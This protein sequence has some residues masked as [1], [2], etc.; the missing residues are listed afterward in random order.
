MSSGYAYM[1]ATLP[2]G[3]V[4]GSDTTLVWA[5]RIP[6][7]R[8]GYDGDG[9]AFLFGNTGK[10]TPDNGGIW[11]KAFRQDDAAGA[12]I[13]V[14]ATNGSGT[15]TLT[16][17]LPA[18]HEDVVI[19]IRN[20]SGDI[21]LDVFR[22]GAKLSGAPTPTAFT[23]V[24]LAADGVLLGCTGD[25][26]TLTPET[27]AAGFGG[28]LAFFGLYDG[29][30]SDANLQDISEGSAISGIGTAANW[31][32]A[33]EYD[34]TAEAFGTPSWATGALSNSFT[35]QGGS[36]RPGS[37]VLP[38]EDGSGNWIALDPVQDGQ[39]WGAAPEAST[40]TI[41]L[42]GAASGVTGD[43]EIRTL[44]DDGTEIA[45][46]TDLAGSTISSGTWSGTLSH[47]LFT[48]GWGHVEVRSKSEPTLVQRSRVKCGCGH[49]FTLVGQSN[50]GT[51]WNGAPSSDTPSNPGPF[52]MV[53][54]LVDANDA[55]SGLVFIDVMDDGAPHPVNWGG[56]A[57]EWGLWKDTPCMVI[58]VSVHGIGYEDLLND[59]QTGW[60]WS[61]VTRSTDVV[62]GDVSAH[63]INWEVSAYTA[64][65]L[66]ELIDGDWIGS[67]LDHYLRDG[68]PFA[69]TADVILARGDGAAF[70]YPDATYPT[71]TQDFDMLFS[72]PVAAG[73]RQ[74]AI[75]TI[76]EAISDYC[77]DNG[78]T[79][80]AML[81]DRK[82]DGGHADGVAS[83]E[84]ACRRN[85]LDF[86]RWTGATVQAN[87][88]IGSVS[89]SED[90]KTIVVTIDKNGAT[91]VLTTE[92]IELSETPHASE[93]SSV[94]GFHTW[95]PSD[96]YPSRSAG[97]ASIY[98]ASAGIIHITKA[99]DT[100]WEKGTE[101]F[102]WT[103]AQLGFGKALRNDRELWKGAPRIKSAHEGGLGL[104][105]V[106]RP[107]VDDFIMARP[108]TPADAFTGSETGDWWI[109]HPDYCTKAGGG[110]PSVG[111]DIERIAGQRGELDWIH[112][113]ALA[114][115]YPILRQSGSVYYIE[116]PSGAALI[117]DGNYSAPEL[118]FQWAMDNMAPATGS[119]QSFIIRKNGATAEWALNVSG[120][121]K[122]IAT[123][124]NNTRVNGPASVDS[125]YG[126]NWTQ[127]WLDKHLHTLRFGSSLSNSDH[128][129]SFDRH[130]GTL[131]SGTAADLADATNYPIE[132]FR[133]L[134]TGNLY[135]GLLVSDPVVQRRQ[136]MGYFDAQMG[137]NV[138]K[139]QL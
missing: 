63:Y 57:E 20:D 14:K 133:G 101:L 129:Y 21:G 73:D 65:K 58:D 51:S 125:I 94:Q 87:P 37:D 132:M 2:S 38:A 54:S 3:T 23:G 50:V 117:T 72:D 22:R 41:R 43:I 93:G 108:W 113:T 81:G 114:S 71:W 91:G 102:Y 124:W 99:D 19:A 95:E 5:G 70:D 112:D 55:G 26:G 35:V 33:G 128:G 79:F 107:R 49:V 85:V 39:V 61:D 119:E 118:R 59:S 80:G 130:S 89:M 76:G 10:A 9:T 6:W 86:A 123:Y 52:S 75:W 135:G 106:Q 88:V 111:D 42:S 60:Q 74:S 32:V 1:E 98:D 126:G 68:S 8:I 13:I 16:H 56:A 110:T 109:I 24:D 100:A 48:G 18:Y 34:A 36:L 28:E 139:F 69:A 67:A 136:E 84:R 78:Y 44:Y 138:L 53:M 30:L 122:K 11:C 15:V 40:A 116:I 4:L 31:D 97:D 12:Q 77:D 90:N 62:G 82:I 105:V 104:P 92:W 83:Q 64:A 66:D 25:D 27:T 45:G 137:G 134:F 96:T 17:D 46:W 120:S 29:V 131:S 103:G 7:Y 127:M 115:D 121:T 47:A